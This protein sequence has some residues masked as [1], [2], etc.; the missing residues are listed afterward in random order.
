MAACAGQEENWAQ[1]GGE[2]R[3]QHWDQEKSR[4]Q[5]RRHPDWRMDGHRPVTK[6]ARRLLQLQWPFL[7][8]QPSS[9]SHNKPV[10]APEAQT[11]GQSI[12]SIALK[13]FSHGFVVM[14]ECSYTNVTRFRSE[15]SK[16]TST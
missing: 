7:A 13:P 14:P 4:R 8:Y 12:K 5:L 3:P 6:L 16:I 2:Q 10:V 11:H 15:T 1:K 9:A